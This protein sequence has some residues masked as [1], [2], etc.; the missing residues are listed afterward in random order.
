MMNIGCE[1]D[2]LYLLNGDELVCEDCVP[3]KYSSL[4][5][6]YST[7]SDTPEHCNRCGAFFTECSLT[8]EGEEYVKT[9]VLSG[10]GNKG[11]LELWR[12]RWS[13]LFTESDEDE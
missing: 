6:L 11:V 1:T 8:S 2:T 3:K 12:D 10:E 4:D 9:L 13:Y 5:E 7:E